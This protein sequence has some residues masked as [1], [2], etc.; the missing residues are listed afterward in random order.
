MHEI[1]GNRSS[2]KEVI[3]L[4]RFKGGVE[5]VFLKTTQLQF[6]NKNTNNAASILFIFFN[7]TVAPPGIGLV[8]VV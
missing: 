6:R 8:S 4:F 1:C 5:D 3:H 2:K 7:I